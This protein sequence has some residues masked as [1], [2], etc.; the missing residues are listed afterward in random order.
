M[1]TWTND[2]L[3]KIEKS[4]ELQ[5]SSLRKDGSLRKPVTIWVV[6]VDNDVYVRSTNGSTASW[7]RGV[8]ERY[9]GHVRVGGI[10]KDVTFTEE[11]DSNVNNQ[12]DE[13]Y[14]TKYRHY[15]S[16]ASHMTESGPRATTIKLAPR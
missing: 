10:D 6:R 8:Q 2:E 14:K 11:T 9:E 7:F 12:I 4:E 16:I 5:I 15:T 3:N 13:A 1:I